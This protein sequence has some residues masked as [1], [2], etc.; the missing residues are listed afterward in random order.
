ML[1]QYKMYRID[2]T[3]DKV[4]NNNKVYQKT[5]LNVDL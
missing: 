4:N 5:V 2:R 3:T 1:I